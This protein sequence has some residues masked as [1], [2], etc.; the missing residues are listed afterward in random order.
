MSDRISPP[1]IFIFVSFLLVAYCVWLFSNNT[2]LVSETIASEPSPTGEAC[3][4]PT[5]GSGALATRTA[6]CTP[7]V[8]T[9]TPSPTSTTTPPI[10]APKLEITLP[11]AKSG[12]K[13]DE[14]LFGG[15]KF[16]DLMRPICRI[17]PGCLSRTL[18]GLPGRYY[19]LVTLVKDPANSTDEN[20]QY[21]VV[22]INGFTIS[23]P[24]ASPTATA[25][26]PGGSPSPGSSPSPDSSPGQ[27]GGGGGGTGWLPNLLFGS[28]R[29]VSFAR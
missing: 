29:T 2:L 14:M 23:A 7:V 27:G 1:R 6:G 21:Y 5:A 3:A 25:T 18:A 9:S 19:A 15:E 20:Y 28:S 4:S 10:V 12:A 26:D 13:P 8:R 22:T 11:I 17:A 16:D 24:P